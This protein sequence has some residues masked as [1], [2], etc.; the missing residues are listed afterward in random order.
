M[1]A[2]KYFTKVATDRINTVADHVISL[3]QSA[4]MAG[5]NKL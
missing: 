5:R 1:S 4:F 2:L 3:T